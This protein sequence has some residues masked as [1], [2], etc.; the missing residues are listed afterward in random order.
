MPRQ[1]QK[2]I[3]RKTF[4][5]KCHTCGKI[6]TNP[7]VYH[8]VPSYKF[9][10]DIPVYQKNSPKTN[11]V[12]LKGDRKVAVYNYCDNKCCEEGRFKLK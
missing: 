5:R 10:Y 1:S 12:D 11:R 9:P 6:A 8:I 3:P 2:R 7:L 4:K